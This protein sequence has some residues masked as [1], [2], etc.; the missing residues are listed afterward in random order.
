MDEMIF[1]NE[2]K[3][4]INTFLIESIKHNQ[5]DE[6]IKKEIKLDRSVVTKLDFIFSDLI[7]NSLKKLSYFDQT[8]FI[9]EEDFAGTLQFPA[10]ILDP[11]DGTK[12]LI[13]KTGEAVISLAY[14]QTQNIHDPHNW[15]W[16]YNPFNGLD[17]YSKGPSRHMAQVCIKEIKKMKTV[18]MS[19]SEYQKIYR[20]IG[21]EN[22]FQHYLQ[23]LLINQSI[24]ILA[25]GSIAYKLAL[26]SMGIGDYVVSF[27]PKNIWD[28]SAGT[29]LLKNKNILMYEN[30]QQIDVL[31]KIKYDSPLAWCLNEDVERV[32]GFILETLKYFK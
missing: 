25:Y 15:G 2:L 17:L 16:V 23:D 1:L 18:L 7:K 8:L 31:S 27:R 20:S 12:D 21:D 24:Q 13:H 3:D 19:K 10:F 4:A 9:S 28:L 14:F 6:L 26:L 22:K 29:I 32:N 11:I 5:F 30:F